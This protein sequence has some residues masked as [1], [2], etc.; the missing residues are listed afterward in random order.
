MV[1]Q[2]IVRFF[3][4]WGILNLILLPIEWRRW[5]K[6]KKSHHLWGFYVYHE[7]WLLTQI[8]LVIDVVFL[9]LSVLGPI[10]YWILEPILP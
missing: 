7:M 10:V 2:V 3:I 5:Q 1:S 9:A 4:V 6:L 8:V